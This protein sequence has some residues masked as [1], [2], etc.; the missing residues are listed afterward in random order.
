MPAMITE[1]LRLL[2][3]NLEM[4]EAVLSRDRGKSEAAL[5]RALRAQGWELPACA[6]FPDEWPNEELI[7]RAFQ[8]SLEAVR[9]S[10]TVI[11]TLC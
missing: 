1:R 7:A 5:D 3:F 2:P 8:L 10:N 6:R 9:T 4:V 11:G